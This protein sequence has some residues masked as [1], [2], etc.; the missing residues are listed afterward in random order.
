MSESVTS[1]ERWQTFFNYGKY[2]L[3][4]VLRTFEIRPNFVIYLK[5]YY[6]RN[7]KTFNPVTRLCACYAI[8]LLLSKRFIKWQQYEY[9]NTATMIL[10]NALQ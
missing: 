4:R 8:Y 3:N 2:T 6:E 9:D 7:D 10:Q 1:K 5:R